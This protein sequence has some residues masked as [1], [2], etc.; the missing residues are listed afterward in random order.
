MGLTEEQQKK[1]LELKHMTN[2]VTE[3]AKQSPEANRTTVAARNPAPTGGCCR[4][5]G[6]F[7]CCQSDPPEEKQDKSS[8]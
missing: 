8:M 6:G 5:G 3:V 7:T 1:A 4:S 2:G